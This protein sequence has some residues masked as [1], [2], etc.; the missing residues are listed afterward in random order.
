MNERESGSERSGTT[1]LEGIRKFAQGSHREG[2]AKPANRAGLSTGF[3]GAREEADRFWSH[4]AKSDGCWSWTAAKKKGYGRF[5]VWR[6][7][8]WTH[9][10]AHRWAL[11]DAT[12]EPIP[13]GIYPDHLCHTNDPVCP[14]GPTCPHRAC[15]RPDHL[16]GTTDD[17]ENRRRARA[18]R[19]P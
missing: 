6:D 3:A 8:R 16:D 13:P 18:R 7:G 17:E 15:V 14:G 19:R 2:P 5:R 10:P 4:V 12:G 11:E 9:M 1:G